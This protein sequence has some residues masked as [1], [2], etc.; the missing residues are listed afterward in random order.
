MRF[1]KIKNRNHIHVYKKPRVKLSRKAVIN[2]RKFLKNDYDC[3]RKL[4]NKGLISK[5]YYDSVLSL[6]YVPV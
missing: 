5:E 6:K 2:L 1:F 3:I 4:K